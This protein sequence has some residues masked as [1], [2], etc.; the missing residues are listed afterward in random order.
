MCRRDSYSAYA[1]E[2]NAYEDIN[3]LAKKGNFPA[4]Y[5]LSKSEWDNTYHVLYEDIDR[6]GWLITASTEELEGEGATT[7]S[8]T[9]LVNPSIRGAISFHTVGKIGERAVSARVNP[10][11]RVFQ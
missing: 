5:T 7:V 1:P 6:T 2:I 3:S 4:H 11:T 9:H 10:C 8:Y